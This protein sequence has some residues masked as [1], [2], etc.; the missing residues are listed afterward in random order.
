MLGVL[1]HPAF[2]FLKNKSILPKRPHVRVGLCRWRARPPFTVGTPSSALE[3]SSSACSCAWWDRPASGGENPL[4]NGPPCAQK[5]WISGNRDTSQGDL[6][7][8]IALVSLNTLH[9]MFVAG[10]ALCSP[11]STKRPKVGHMP[12]GPCLA[13]GPCLEPPVAKGWRKIETWDGWWSLK[14]HIFTR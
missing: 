10:L 5:V 1:D 11:S 9:W 8:R 13:G 14:R 12:A 4:G 7:T 6:G 3:A 2:L